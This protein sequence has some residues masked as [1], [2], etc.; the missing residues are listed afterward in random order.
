MGATTPA[1]YFS[2]PETTGTP[3]LSPASIA[4]II[5]FF[6][7]QE[8]NDSG[9]ASEGFTYTL[10]KFFDFNDE[11]TDEAAMDFAIAVNGIVRKIAHFGIYAVLGFFIALLLNAYR[12]IYWHTVI[13]SALSSLLY[14]CTDELHQYFVPGRSAQLSDIV[15]DTL[16]ALCGAVFAIIII[17][18]VKKHCEKHTAK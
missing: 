4:K 3:P 17:V 5:F 15:I 13:Y 2:E 1:K 12:R 16:G 10:I 18:L 14:S 8:A 11:I 9:R 7:A 6:S